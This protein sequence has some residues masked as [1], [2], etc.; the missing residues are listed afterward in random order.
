MKVLLLEDDFKLSSEVR[1]FL[2]EK[3]MEC[4][5]VYDGNLFMKQFRQAEYDLLILDIN[6]PGINGMEVCAQVRQ[7]NK[8]TPIIMLTAFGEIEDK[9]DAFNRGADDYLVKPFHFDEL[10]IRIQSLMRRQLQPQNADEI[11]KIENLEINLSEKK[12]YR[13]S[14]EI[15]LSPKEYQLLVLLAGANGRTVSKQTISESVWDINF[16]TGTNTIEVYIN[17]LRKKIDRDFSPKLIHTRPG[18]GYYLKSEE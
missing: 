12:V 6:V 3:K 15:S 16:E 14:N 7:V 5:A 4:D 8:V 2:E 1:V 10:F 18:F 11:I 9:V 13:D 17:F